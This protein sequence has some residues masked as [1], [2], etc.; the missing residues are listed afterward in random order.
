MLSVS[1]PGRTG[2]GYA[3]L[4]VF[5]SPTVAVAIASTHYAYPRLDGQAE[6]AWLA[7]ITTKM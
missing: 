5:S 4:A 7:G 2:N 6:L 1:S 3:E